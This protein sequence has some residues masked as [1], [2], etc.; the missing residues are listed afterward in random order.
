M[1]R[2]SIALALTI[3]LIASVG[4]AQQTTTKS[5]TSSKPTASTTPP[6]G[7]IIGG[8]GTTNYI[9]VW[10]DPVFLLDSVIY[11]ANGDIGIGTTTPAAKLDVNGAINTST[12]YQIDGS[13]VV[14]MGFT[15]G[16]G[17]IFLGTLAGQNNQGAANDVFVGNQ[18]G[19]MNTT[20]FSNTF[21]GSQ[22]GLANTTGP[23]NAFYGYQA[24]ASNTT[25][26][27]NTFTG[28]Y[29]G[30]GNTTGNSNSFYGYQA[31]ASNTTGSS[32]TFNGYTAGYSNNTGMNNTF[33]GYTAGYRNTTG[34]SNA[35]YGNG[36]G[37]NNTT[38]FD[39][40][41]NGMS[42]GVVN[43]TGG[44]NT[45]YGYGAGGS[46]T[47][48]MENTFVGWG[49]GSYT[50]TGNNN[51]YIGNLG[52]SGSE[53]STI[54]IG[55]NIEEGYG[56][57]TSTYIAGIYGVNVAGVP[58]QINSSGQLGAATSSLRF[59]E[60]VH[61]MGDSTS[62]L[63]KLRPVTFLYKPEASNGERTLQ[64]GLIAEE[65]AK[66][67]PELVA[68]DK[69]GQPYA[70]RYQYLSAMLLNEAQKQYR[71]AEAQAEV[72]KTEEQ[73][74]NSQ[75]HEIDEMQQRLSKLESLIRTRTNSAENESDHAITGGGQ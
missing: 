23:N 42:A 56:A 61:D 62:A 30:F 31:G 60:Q 1:R 8:M 32:N 73:K 69:D 33:T 72:I 29:A 34:S 75:Q 11:Q 46:N 49:A 25:A 57:Q 64:Y 74:I 67:Y 70:V 20:G 36:A 26:G 53:S 59:K 12:T 48:G 54:R 51:I 44:F 55:G 15:V 16:D 17:N 18:A 21:S 47:T 7:P 65:V 38:G 3:L 39:N 71:R 63:M 43:T 40:T 58:V 37:T 14:S 50:T 9:P 19:Q 4:S 68:Y 24:G 35:F 10:A 2:I 66:V 45:F 52:I 22:A 27:Q 6:P 13:T 5:S 41:F 28:A